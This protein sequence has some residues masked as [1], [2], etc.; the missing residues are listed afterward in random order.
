MPLVEQ[1]ARWMNCFIPY[2]HEMYE[3]V[4]IRGDGLETTF[5]KVN[6]PSENSE[7]D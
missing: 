2:M 4:F 6:V 7:G 1:M 3:N 5:R